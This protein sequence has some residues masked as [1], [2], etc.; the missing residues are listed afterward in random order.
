MSTKEILN[1]IS[2]EIDNQLEQGDEEYTSDTAAV[3]EFLAE[4]GEPGEMAVWGFD[5]ATFIKQH[6]DDTASSN[7]EFMLGT[8]WLDGLMVGLRLAEHIR[9]EVKDI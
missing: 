8:I 7:I 2:A 5:R 6:M 9:D 4:Y 1:T 3:E